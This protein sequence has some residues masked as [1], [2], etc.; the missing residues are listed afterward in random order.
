MAK[1]LLQ[2]KENQPQEAAGRDVNSNTRPGSCTHRPRGH[3][4][5]GLIKACDK[6]GGG[7]EVPIYPGFFPTR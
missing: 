3:P 7:G 2:G 4:E 6:G 1:Q 5:V